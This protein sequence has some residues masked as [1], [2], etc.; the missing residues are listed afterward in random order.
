M[1]ENQTITLSF[2]EPDIALLTIDAPDNSV[3]LLSRAVM[4][5]LEGQLDEI[6]ARGNLSLIHI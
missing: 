5:E 4:D 1:A 3:N 6:D 2:P